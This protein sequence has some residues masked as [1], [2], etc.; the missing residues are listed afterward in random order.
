[1]ADDEQAAFA[2]AMFDTVT[3]ARRAGFE[4]DF[5]QFADLELPLADVRAPTLLIHARTDADVLY[6]Q[7]EHAVGAVLGARL[8]TVDVGTHLSA[9]LGPGAD[10]LQT[11]ITDH[12]ASAQ[13]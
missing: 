11:A 3:G 1:M 8:V 5:R 12:L 4:N 13:T 7:S 10:S 6:D 9:W 2:V